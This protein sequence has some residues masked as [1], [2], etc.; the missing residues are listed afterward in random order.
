MNRE[1][2]TFVLPT[3]DDCEYELIE[4]NH[5]VVCVIPTVTL[6]T[7]V[8][9]HTLFQDI[10]DH[11]ITLDRDY[12]RKIYF[13]N[14]NVIYR[15]IRFQLFGHIRA[16]LRK[17]LRKLARIDL[18]ISGKLDYNWIEPEFLPRFS[19]EIDRRLDHLE[20]RV[21]DMYRAFRKGKV[22]NTPYVL[23]ED[24]KVNHTY[25]FD[26]HPTDIVPVFETFVVTQPPLTGGDPEE[27][28]QML[29]GKF[30]SLDVK[31]IFKEG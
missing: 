4:Q 30:N 23:P 13:D 20:K 5:G 1:N 16:A 18:L 15:I 7:P 8:I 27:V 2:I 11:L 9:P 6:H 21:R 14:T 24:Y 22:K 17:D 26:V 3:G 31:L 29:R 19:D 10:V 25:Y 12:V 28:S